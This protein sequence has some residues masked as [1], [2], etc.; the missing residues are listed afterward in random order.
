[1]K[2]Y[3]NYITN[4][5]SAIAK[6]KSMKQRRDHFDKSYSGFDSL[7]NRLFINKNEVLCYK[8]LNS[9]QP[10]SDTVGKLNLED[11][12]L[13]EHPDFKYLR[14]TNGSEYHYITSAFIDIKNSTGL[15]RKYSPDVVM[16]ITNIIQ[17]A[18]I[19]T[20]VI[21]GGYIQRLQGDGLFVYFGGRDVSKRNS[22]V[23]AITATSMFTYFVKND[24]KNV[25]VEEGIDD[26]NTR[27]GI[28]FGDDEKVLWSVAG[29]GECSEITTT[30]L[31]TS[32]ASKMQA[33]ANTN[34]IVVGE[35][36]KTYSHVED[37]YFD[38]VR[39]GS[40][41][42]K[43]RY[44]FED[45]K[46]KFYYKA[47]DFDWLSFLKKL[48]FIYENDLGELFFEAD[49]GKVEKYRLDRLRKTSALLSTGSAYTN[50]Q[51]FISDRSSGVK[52]QQHRFHYGEEDKVSKKEA[53]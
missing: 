9:L 13:G 25:L 6:D 24:L 40:G 1:M 3:D 32:L 5:R 51:G 49:K 45:R 23:D 43:Q 33:I 19:H 21:F 53:K 30:S 35:Y 34:G 47:L 52:N 8:P 20:C 26:I 28:D 17:R 11:Q 29:M 2:L 22:V 39:N 27:I 48:P 38:W 18:A 44:I 12:K 16:V 50:Q 7:A 46:N 41:Q 4:I 15:F 14:K 31:H 10:L 36:V 37:N 42:I